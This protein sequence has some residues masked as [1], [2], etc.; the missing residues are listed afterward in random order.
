MA[1]MMSK[2]GDKVIPV[3]DG[4]FDLKMFDVYDKMRAYETSYGTSK[5][6]QGIIKKINHMLENDMDTIFIAYKAASKVFRDMKEYKS[7]A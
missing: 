3:V 2:L 5:D 1:L 7:Y 6:K 4:N